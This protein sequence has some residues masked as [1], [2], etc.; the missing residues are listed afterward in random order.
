M[1]EL[2]ARTRRF[3]RPRT[4]G[5]LVVR[6]GLTAVVLLGAGCSLMVGTRPDAYPFPS[7]QV[8]DV[9]PGAVID[10][11]NGYPSAQKVTLQRNVY[12]DL[13]NF[14]ATAVGIVGRELAKKGVAIEPHAAKKVVLRIIDPVWTIGMWSMKA[15]V[16]IQADFAGRTITADGPYQTAGNAMRAFNGAILRGCVALLQDPVLQAYLNGHFDA[17]PAEEPPPAPPEG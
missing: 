17:P 12:G 13:H 1:M 8:F 3:E 14:T 5:T 9:R 15:N 2:L 16:T 10:V 4:K 6:L 11:V 7:E